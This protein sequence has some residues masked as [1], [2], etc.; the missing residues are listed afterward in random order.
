MSERVTGLRGLDLL[1]A[2]QRQILRAYMSPHEAMPGRDRLETYDQHAQFMIDFLLYPEEFEPTRF[3]IQS[4]Y[5]AFVLNGRLNGEHIWPSEVEFSS[6]NRNW[7]RNIGSEVVYRYSST[8]S[9]FTA[10]HILSAEVLKDPFNTYLGSRKE[11]E[12][13]EDGGVAFSL[14]AFVQRKPKTEK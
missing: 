13:R 5:C 3:A 4:A 9:M 12:R 1:D 8:L 7:I 6:I 2:N 10:V 14:E 11:W